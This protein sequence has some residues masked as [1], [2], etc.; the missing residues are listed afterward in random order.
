MAAV[1]SATAVTDL[2]ND[3]A[4]AVHRQAELDADRV[5]RLLTRDRIDRDKGSVSVPQWLLFELAAALRLEQWE[6]DGISVHVEA[7]LPSARQ[8]LAGVYQALLDQLKR[9]QFRHD[10][11]L[12]FQ[13]NALFAERF[14]WRSRADLDADLLLGGV[15]EEELVDV[16]ARLLWIHRPVKRPENPME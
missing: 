3:L 15:D 9:A 10:T 12:L 1:S 2:P 5:G 16:L 7:G 13:V 4:D 14:A 11:P 8:A 6:K